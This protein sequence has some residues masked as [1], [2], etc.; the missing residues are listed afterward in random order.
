MLPRGSRWHQQVQGHDVKYRQRDNVIYI[1]MTRVGIFNMNK[2]SVSRLIVYTTHYYAS[3]S[4]S[5][6]KAFGRITNLP[7]SFFV[8]VYPASEISRL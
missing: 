8:I 7:F 1:F 2:V 6:L 3:A 5:S 4:A